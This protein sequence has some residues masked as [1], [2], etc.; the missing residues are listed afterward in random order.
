VRVYF[1]YTVVECSKDSQIVLPK[2]CPQKHTHRNYGIRTM[3]KSS[4][5]YTTR[6]KRNLKKKSS[7]TPPTKF[8]LLV[9]KT[10]SQNAVPKMPGKNP[11]IRE[12]FI[13]KEKPSYPLSEIFSLVAEILD[14][15]RYHIA[16][17]FL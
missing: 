13:T 2:K 8:C 7:F 6:T 4:L 12:D 3:L 14:R 1:L 9:E 16:L 10:I 11:Q 5:F 15:H 17:C